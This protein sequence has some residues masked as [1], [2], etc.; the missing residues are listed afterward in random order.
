M[1]MSLSAFCQWLSDTQLSQTIQNVSWII[2]SVQSV[3]ILSISI[4]IS[5][6]FLVDLRLLGVIGR[7]TPTATYTQRFLPWIWPTLVVLLCTGVTL[8]IGEPAR[9]LQNAAFQFKMVTLIAAMTLTFFLQRPLRTNAAYWEETGR[10]RVLVKL[11]A[12]VSLVL[13]VSIV[14]AGRWIAYMNTAGE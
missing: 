2:P 11:M 13:W 12:L 8:I 1:A 10:R 14:F 7:N 3:H 5:A 4:V 6:V 9:S